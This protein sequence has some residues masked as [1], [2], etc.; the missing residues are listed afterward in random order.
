MLAPVLPLSPPPALP[1]PPRLHHPSSCLS[2][3][4][5]ERLI[6]EWQAGDDLTGVMTSACSRS[7]EGE[8]ERRRKAEA[9]AW[10]WLWTDNTGR[11]TRR[12]PEAWRVAWPNPFL[13]A[14]WPGWLLTSQQA[15]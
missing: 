8:R 12:R 14:A 11:P 2:A 7:P 9:A 4:T 1:L 3:G 10:G 15:N 5:P 13:T 6:V